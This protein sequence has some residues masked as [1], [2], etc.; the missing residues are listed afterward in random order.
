M[1]PLEQSML[2]STKRDL[3]KFLAEEL[4][5][6]GYRGQEPAALAAIADGAAGA[7]ESRAL[8]E[9]TAD[10]QRTWKP[11]LDEL[12]RRTYGRD[13]SVDGEAGQVT[14]R[15]V[16]DR[17]CGVPDRLYASDGTLLS[18]DARWPD[19][20]L[21]DIGFYL[22]A[23]RYATYA[24]SMGLTFEQFAAIFRR[25]LEHIRNFAEIGFHVAE[26]RSSARMYVGFERLGGSTLAW[27]HLANDSC[28]D[29]EQR[30]TIR[31]WN[32]DY[33]FLV[34]VHECLHAAGCPHTPGP[35]VMNPS[36]IPTLAGMTPRDVENLLS[37]GYQRIEPK[38]DPPSDP[39]E[40]G[41][42]YRA[43]VTLRNGQTL[44]AD[45]IA[46]IRLDLDLA[47]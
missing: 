27:S 1:S 36:I 34:A 18:A 23:A 8:A 2:R 7:D 20:C 9:A 25:A 24:A 26:D 21:Q 6:L 22:D 42:G 32:E 4:F 10:Y 17:T 45:A 16:L 19:A 11:D 47:D 41:R 15:H 35:Y 13:L 38:P 40:P 29:K 5:R 43:R 37:R 39:D 31:D 12:A 3:R 30:Y 28:G 33:L 14:L 46:R 44:N